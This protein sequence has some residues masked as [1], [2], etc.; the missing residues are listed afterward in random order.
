VPQN[1]YAK[2]TILSAEIFVTYIW[3]EAKLYFPWT[4][5]IYSVLSNL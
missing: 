5:R 2:C 3:E 4:G 1:H